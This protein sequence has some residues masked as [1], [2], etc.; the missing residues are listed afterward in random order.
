M[1]AA[2]C[3]SHTTLVERE[4]SA[5]GVGAGSGNLVGPVLSLL[6]RLLGRVLHLV[7]ALTWTVGG[8]V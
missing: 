3:R 8:G 4:G 7:Q 6:R 2:C 5:R 1:P